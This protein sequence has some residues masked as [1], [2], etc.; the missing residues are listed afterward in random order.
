MNINFKLNASF[1]L[2]SSPTT[3][4]TTRLYICDPHCGRRSDCISF[5]VQSN[6]HALRT[7]TAPKIDFK[8]GRCVSD[9]L[10]ICMCAHAAFW[11]CKTFSFNVNFGNLMLSVLLPFWRK[12]GKRHFVFPTYVTDFSPTGTLPQKALH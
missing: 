8:R 9:D 3:I 11:M 2:L 1:A 5:R 12:Q 7:K 10:R 6:S 4:C